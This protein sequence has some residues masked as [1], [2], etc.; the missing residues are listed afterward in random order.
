MD[1]KD[2]CESAKSPNHVSPVSLPLPVEQ[3][4]HLF[5][6]VQ[7]VVAPTMLDHRVTVWKAVVLTDFLD[8]QEIP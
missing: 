8:S 7:Q 6:L 3:E 4:G 5:P 2:V 1:R